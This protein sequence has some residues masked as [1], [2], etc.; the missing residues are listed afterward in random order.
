MG[1]F[2][3][4]GERFSVAEYFYCLR[5]SSLLPKVLTM[6]S[7]YDFKNP[8]V[9]NPSLT[10]NDLEKI[11]LLQSQILEKAVVSDDYDQVLDELCL[12]AESYTPSSVA[13]IM[14]VDS[15]TQTLNVVNG[16]SLSPEAVEAFN[17]LRL[18]EGS[19]GNAVLHGKE[20]YVCD[21]HKDLR[22]ENLRR[23]AEE[24]HISSC[25]SFPIVNRHNHRIGTFSISRFEQCQPEGFHKALLDACASICGVIF[26]RRA[27]D[28]IRQQIFDEKLRAGKLSSLG[29]LAGGIAHDFNNLLGAILGN[30]DLAVSTLPEG[31]AKQSLEWSMK[32]IDRACG[33]TQQLLT[34]SRGGT[35]VRQPADIG[36]IIRDSLEFTLLGSNMCFTI[37][38]LDHECCCVLDVDAG[39]IGQLIQN[40]AMNARQACEHSGGEI[41]VSCQN[42][43][44]TDHPS[45]DAGD[46]FKIDF[47]DN[48]PGIS[49]EMQQR[50]FDPYFT[51]RQDGT[52]LG[53]ALCYSIVTNHNGYIS[54]QS[55]P[56]DGAEF[57]ITLPFQVGL[58][59]PQQQPVEPLNKL[60]GGRAIV[61]DDEEMIRSAVSRMTN[62]LGFETL[63][64]KDG[65]EVLSL[66]ETAEKEDKPIDLIIVDLTVPGGMGGIDTKDQILQRNP[67]AKIVVSSGYSENPILSNYAEHGFCGAVA[68]PFRMVD[69]KAVLASILD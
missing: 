19:C 7:Q 25:F 28:E 6:T 40:L 53:L 59:L 10:A 58:K 1:V 55:T 41:I 34:F 3:L 35:P 67:D 24:F 12:L 54:V 26:Q 66:L 57:S 20:I 39:Q 44:I 64:A 2:L 62:T 13:A 9:I 69:L 50:I 56:P 33:L 52:G 45:L 29:M 46:Y 61:M 17:G 23:V 47:A 15:A 4:L 36:A 51:T 31:A 21:T 48:G 11:L 30:I 8:T 14:S 27:D 63:A 37:D 22:W 5:Y 18:G 65:S 60:S 38:G 49:D 42:V 43:T 16:P 68:K 32:A